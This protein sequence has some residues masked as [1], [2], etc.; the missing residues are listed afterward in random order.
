MPV[1]SR[2]HTETDRRALG[3]ATEE[4]V[5]LAALISAEI[6]VV[7]QL[8]DRGSVE[9]H[10]HDGPH[11][12]LS[13]IGVYEIHELDFPLVIWFTCDNAVPAAVLE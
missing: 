11:G 6:A 9:F 7:H 3:L 5:L 2:R 1:T 4:P 12:Q 10:Y 13:E 8:H